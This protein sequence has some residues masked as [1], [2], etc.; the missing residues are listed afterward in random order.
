VGDTVKR[1]IE[2]HEQCLRNME[3]SAFSLIDKRNQ[4]NLEIARAERDCLFKRKQ[5][6]EAQFRGMTEFDDGKLLVKKGKK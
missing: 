6:T 4:L 2:W 5:I 1:P 3:K